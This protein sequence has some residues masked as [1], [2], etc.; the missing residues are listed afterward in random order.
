MIHVGIV[1]CG[2]ILAAHLRGYQLL[3]EAGVDDFR[4]TAI[5]ARRADDAR[6]YIRRSVRQWV[7]APVILC[8]SATYSCQTFKTMWK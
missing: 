1:G 3:R 7:P 4:I 5:C 2:R 6:M 8:R